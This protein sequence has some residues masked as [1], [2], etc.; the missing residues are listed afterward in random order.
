MP[1]TSTT[2][3]RSI[4]GLPAGVTFHDAAI[5]LA[6]DGA[7][8]YVLRKIGQASLAVTTSLEY[9]PIYGAGQVLIQLKHSPVVGIVALTN[10]S[11]A[12][13]SDQYILEAETGEISLKGTVFWSIERKGVQIQ[14]GWGYD[15]STVPEELRRAADLI[16]MSSYNRSRNAGKKSESE[17]GYRYELSE[18]L[19]PPEARVILANYVDTHHS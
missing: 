3:I 7:N 5:G 16:A 14:Y 13:P 1:L 10:G 17:G 4:T 15:E 9:P 12:V 2:R 19:I 8:A 6:V 11:Y 18:E